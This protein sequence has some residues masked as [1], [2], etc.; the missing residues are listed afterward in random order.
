[1]LNRRSLIAA[2]L[3]AATP[4]LARVPGV[5]TRPETA[6]LMDSLA[7]IVVGNALGPR[8]RVLFSP[9][10]EH[11]TI[12]WNS[13][14]VHL[15]GARWSWVPYGG[16]DRNRR[17][18]AAALSRGGVEGISGAL[19]GTLREA[20]DMGPMVRQDD[21]V[22]RRLGRLLWE[23]T[24]TALATPTLVFMRNDGVFHAVRGSI[25]AP[26]VSR[27]LGAAA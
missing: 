4:A 1:M 25:D 6:D 8:V 18:C 14:Q 21:I 3:F 7:A 11:S 27:M 16:F 17:L 5:I 10:C 2:G 19:D 13:I 23:S 20:S 12:L 9:G 22:S 15:G 24:N 26:T